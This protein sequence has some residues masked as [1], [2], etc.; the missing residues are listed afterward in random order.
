MST[1]RTRHEALPRWVHETAELCKPDRVYL[2]DGLQ[3]EYDR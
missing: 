2:C 1:A 3:E